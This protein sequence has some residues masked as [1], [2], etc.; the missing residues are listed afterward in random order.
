MNTITS[1]TSD[2]VMSP[3]TGDERQPR[4]SEADVARDF[5]ALFVSMMIKE[6][7]QAGSEEGLFA[8]DASDT[9]GGLFDTFMGEHIAA[10]RGIGL[11]RL[12]EDTPSLS[13]STGHS[14]DAHS[15]DAQISAAL[16]AA[17][18]QQA[19]EAYGH[20]TSLTN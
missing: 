12:F 3:L 19:L 5:E 18:K 17:R 8:G 9:F 11:S 14:R 2:S 6:M 10:G 15:R 4:G 20:G 1:I 16:D 7:R 13:A